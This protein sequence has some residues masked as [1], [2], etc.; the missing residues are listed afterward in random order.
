MNETFEQMREYIMIVEHFSQDNDIILENIDDIILE[1]IDEN[2]YLTESISDSV[3][4]CLLSDLKNVVFKLRAFTESE[5]TDTAYGIELGMQRAS[6]M[7]ENIISR[8]EAK[9]G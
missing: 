5:M 8:Y 3:N 7:I 2:K 6:D 1:N 9:N 4:V